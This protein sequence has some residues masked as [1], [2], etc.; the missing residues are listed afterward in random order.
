MSKYEGIPRL[1]S[2][3]KGAH[4]NMVEMAVAGANR[5]LKLSEYYVLGSH[6]QI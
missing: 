6:S 1:L 5:N 2:D 3:L 4:K